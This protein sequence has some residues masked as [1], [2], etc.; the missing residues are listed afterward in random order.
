[1]VDCRGWRSP[2]EIR[3]RSLLCGRA[4]AA[5]PCTSGQGHACSNAQGGMLG[6]AWPQA[7][8]GK[9]RHKLPGRSSTTRVTHPIGDR[10][11]C[12]AGVEPFLRQP[13]VALVA[14][15]FSVLLASM[16]GNHREFRISRF[17][18]HPCVD[19]Y[20][21]HPALPPFVAIRRGPALRS[22]LW[23][24]LERKRRRPRCSADQECSSVS[25][26]WST[27]RLPRR[28]ILQP[29][30]IAPRRRLCAVSAA[31]TTGTK[32]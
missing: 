21:F 31:T 27:L 8:V 18:H 20:I 28:N 2:S 24:D 25:N 11:D 15:S 1:M 23:Q 13:R 9:V 3:P 19:W 14:L 30:L 17:N 16:S 4:C 6:F 29:F 32:S 12:N 26:I 7:S 22:L 5:A 10:L